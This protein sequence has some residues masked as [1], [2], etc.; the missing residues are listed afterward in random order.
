MASSPVSL[1]VLP[2]Q[3][4]RAGLPGHRRLP[5][6]R[7]RLPRAVP[8]PPPPP[9]ASRCNRRGAMT[10]IVLRGGSLSGFELYY[11]DGSG[12]GLR[13]LPGDVTPPHGLRF[14]RLLDQFSRLEAAAPPPPAS[15]PRSSR[16]PP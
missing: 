15:R 5:R 8:Q 13:P 11:E 3:P 16:C 7:R 4:L 12:D 1:L 2:L 6:L 9:R 10:V 14:H